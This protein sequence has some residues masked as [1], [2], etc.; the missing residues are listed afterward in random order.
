VE[1]LFGLYSVSKSVYCFVEV[2][3]FVDAV[4]LEMVFHTVKDKRELEIVVMAT[5]LL[6][7]ATC[8]DMETAKKFS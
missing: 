1:S 8:M 5:L 6:S 4:I 7:S 3:F 2:A